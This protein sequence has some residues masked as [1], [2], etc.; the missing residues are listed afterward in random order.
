MDTRSQLARTLGN[1][2]PVSFSPDLVQSNLL[3]NANIVV[4]EDPQ[5]NVLRLSASAMRPE[6]LIKAREEV[7]RE[8]MAELVDEFAN[9]HDDLLR[10][11]A[12]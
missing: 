6:P 11:L 10:K 3:Y 12:R 1:L 8:L 7:R 4:L 9:T 2:A 5:I